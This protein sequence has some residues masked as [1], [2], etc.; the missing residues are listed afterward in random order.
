MYPFYI[1]SFCTINP[2]SNLEIDLQPMNFNLSILLPFMVNSIYIEW[3]MGIFKH[4]VCGIANF[5]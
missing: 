3:L 4:A 1:F 2:I 5:E